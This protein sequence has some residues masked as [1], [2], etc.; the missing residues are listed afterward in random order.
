MQKMQKVQQLLKD[1]SILFSDTRLPLYDNVLQ[2]L[3]AF[4]IRIYYL[5]LED[6]MKRIA[7][8]SENAPGAQIPRR[9]SQSTGCENY[10]VGGVG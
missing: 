6:A 1:L 5:S 8:P 2:G 7:T 10:G 9:I 4:T 3:P